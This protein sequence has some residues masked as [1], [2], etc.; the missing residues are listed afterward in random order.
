MGDDELEH[1]FGSDSYA[2]RK[3]IQILFYSCHSFSD[4]EL[5]HSF[6]SKQLWRSPLVITEGGDILSI[7]VL[8]ARF[9]IT[10]GGDIEITAAT[11]VAEVGTLTEWRVRMSY[12]DTLNE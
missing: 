1:S 7:K 9:V 8:R 12:V 3:T 4:D 2:R 11:Q 6:I 5:E 10:E